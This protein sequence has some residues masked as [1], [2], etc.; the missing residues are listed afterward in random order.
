MDPAS[1]A[2][3]DRVLLEQR[4]LNA[5][6]RVIMDKI[7]HLYAGKDSSLRGRHR[8]LTKR[9]E[10]RVRSPVW[11]ANDVRIPA[12]LFPLPGYNG[13]FAPARICSSTLSLTLLLL[14]LARSDCCE[15]ACSDRD[16]RPPARSRGRP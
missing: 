16:T 4:D 13:A 12:H 8:I 5:P 11:T 14:P 6:Y 3:V 9:P 1:L 15:R 2:I 10:Q 7:K